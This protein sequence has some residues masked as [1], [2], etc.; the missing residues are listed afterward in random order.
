S[1]AGGVRY[2]RRERRNIR[3][4]IGWAHTKDVGHDPFA[5]SHRRGSF[6]FCR[7]HQKR[8][9]PRQSLSDIH[10]RTERDAAKLATV[11][12]RNTVM[13]RQPLVD[14][15]VVG[16]Q[17]IRHIS[18]LANDTVEQQLYFASHR[19]PQRIVEVRKEHRDWTHSLQTSQVQPLSGK[20][21]REC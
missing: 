9:L 18:V 21:D 8:A 19:L 5:A 11:N 4:W 2:S 13:L 7:C 14:E 12:V 3:W 20:V 1:V 16:S 10:I 15:C 6:R 17:Q